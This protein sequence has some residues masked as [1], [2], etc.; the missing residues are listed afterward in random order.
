MFEIGKQKVG[1][2]FPRAGEMGALE[3]EAGVG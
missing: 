2:W 3:E 1:S